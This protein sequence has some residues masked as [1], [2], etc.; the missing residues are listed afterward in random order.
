MAE[1]DKP[2]ADLITYVKQALEAGVEI[3]VLEQG[4]KDAEIDVARQTA[5][6]LAGKGGGYPPAFVEMLVG[7]RELR[8]AIEHVR[9][10]NY[11]PVFGAITSPARSGATSVA[12]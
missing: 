1:A 9:I 6:T 2:R 10:E 5:L 3:R 12:G 7:L 8:G 4:A 11:R